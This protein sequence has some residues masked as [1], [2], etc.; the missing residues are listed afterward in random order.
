MIVLV[1]N[2]GVIAFC[3]ILLLV[4]VEENNVSITLRYQIT[5]WLWGLLLIILTF[6]FLQKTCKV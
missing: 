1:L 4:N 3:K 2:I 6:L 5:V